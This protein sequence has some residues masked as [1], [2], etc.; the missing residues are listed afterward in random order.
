MGRREGQ[1]KRRTARTWTPTQAT[2][3]ADPN[4]PGGNQRLDFILFFKKASKV[5]LLPMFIRK[6]EHGRDL[7][8]QKQDELT[9]S[10]RAFLFR[11]MFD[12]LQTRLLE[13]VKDPSRLEI[14]GIPPACGR[15]SPAA[16][17]LSGLQPGRTSLGT[18][19]G[20]HAS[21]ERDSMCKRVGWEHTQHYCE[22]LY[23]LPRMPRALWT[24]HVLRGNSAD[25]LGACRQECIQTEVGC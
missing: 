8:N 7:K 22:I 13:T 10:L 21:R 16:D 11:S 1:K 18:Q 17:T 14:A 4:A 5:S 3:L 6:S 15:G 24:R 9:L 23:S 19:A 2:P 12:A 25:G 20:C